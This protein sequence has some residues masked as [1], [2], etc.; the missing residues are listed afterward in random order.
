MGWL[1]RGR[2]EGRDDAAET[3]AYIARS[4][5]SAEKLAGEREASKAAYAERLEAEANGRGDSPSSGGRPTR[6][7]R[8]E[9]DFKAVGEADKKRSRE[10]Y[11]RHVAATSTPPRR[12]V[13]RW[14]G[15]G[16]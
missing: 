13:G 7:E 15:K 4:F 3:A 10:M 5:A 2:S 14:L 11:E 6:G 1:G 12:G 9:D 8:R 16:Q